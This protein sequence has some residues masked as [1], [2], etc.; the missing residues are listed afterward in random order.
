MRSARE[1]H[2]LLAAAAS[3]A[4]PARL[5]AAYEARSTRPRR[6]DDIVDTAAVGSACYCGKPPSASYGVVVR[7]GGWVGSIRPRHGQSRSTVLGPCSRSTQTHTHTCTHVKGV[8]ACSGT[9]GVSVSTPAQRLHEGTRHYVTVP[10]RVRVR[11]TTSSSRHLRNA[12]REHKSGGEC[13]HLT[14]RQI[15]TFG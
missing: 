5:R 7:I 6:E 2:H 4:A 10:Q 14:S 3:R 9:N 1:P 8:I 15:P 12:G 11:P 13:D